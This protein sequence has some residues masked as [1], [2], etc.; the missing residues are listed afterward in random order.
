MTKSFIFIFLIISAFVNAQKPLKKK[1]LGKY[2][3]EISAYKINTGSQFI[4]V[5]STSISL[6]IQ[7]NELVFTIGRNEMTIPYSWIK[8][9]KKTIQIEF[10]R[11][12]DET[13]EIVILTK[14]TKEIL[15]EGV[16]PQ[17]KCILKKAKK[18]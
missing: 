14:K 1:F 17:P 12:V 5:S 4:D 15:R 18:K 7:K 2:E 10:L 3:G 11:S 16:Y 13:K 8:K 6:N 9:D